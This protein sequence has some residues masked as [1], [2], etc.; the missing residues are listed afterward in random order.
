MFKSKL[1]EISRRKYKSKDQKS[2]LLYKSGEVVIK[3]FNDYSSI[4]SKA[5]YKT[6]H[7]KGIPSMSALVARGR[8]AKVSDNSN[9]KILSPKQM[10]QR[11]P[12]A[13]VQ[14]KAGNTSETY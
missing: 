13:L 10:P 9:I 7:G 14:A 5:K 11:L 1:N 6:I 4:A 8:V 3:L 12:I 2:A